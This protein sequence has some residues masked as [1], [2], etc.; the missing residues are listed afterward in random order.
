MKNPIEYLSYRARYNADA[1]ALVFGG[2]IL[3]FSDLMSAVR[4]CAARL[5]RQGV[6]S[7]QTVSI[8]ITDP[9]L[10][11]V[12]TLAVMHEGA[13][14]CSA[15]PNYDPMPPG[16]PLDVYVTDR[17]T[18][19][20]SRTP[21]VQVDANWLTESFSGAQDISPNAFGGPDAF[22]RIVASS[23]T[24][25]EPKAIPLTFQMSRE[26]VWSASGTELSG[27]ML[28]MMTVSTI[29]GYQ[30]AL[31]CI[32]KGKPL[33]F[34]FTPLAVERSIELT[35][36]TNLLA[37]PVQ[38]GAL[39]Q[40]LE[41]RTTRLFSLKSLAFAGAVMPKSLAQRIRARLLPSLEGVYG[42]TEAGMVTAASPLML[43][44]YS[45]CAGLVV[46]G[47]EV[48]L[49]DENG[50][51]VPEGQDGSIRIRTLGMATE[52]LGDPEGT[53]EAFRDGWFYPGD[54]GRFVDG[55]VLLITGRD[56]ELINLGGSKVNP[57]IIDEFLAEQPGIRDAAAF[58]ISGTDGLPQIWAAVVVDHEID[59]GQLL[60]T[61]R[62]QFGAK[63][64]SRIFAIDS[65]VR[66]VMGKT[67]REQV[68]DKVLAQIRSTSH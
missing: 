6:C 1:V 60:A 35:G 26:R 16:M 19:F 43:E 65:V 22:V 39:V 57:V 68:R 37:S 64:P 17:M 67:Q 58:S 66:N 30:S 49:V 31:N 29:G 56:A 8:Y 7:G 32:V 62:K 10:H 36:V 11:W 33:V 20:M 2:R 27:P 18:P 21:V 41:G 63:A 28:S 55:G 15:H 12:L 34:A 61:A 9:V 50:T 53:Q 52:Y 42:S 46:P 51:P 40:H 48:E 25:G 59:V 4:N 54:R 5:R 47:A 45:G 13:A 44:K 24:T 3:S 14:S 38:L 23:G